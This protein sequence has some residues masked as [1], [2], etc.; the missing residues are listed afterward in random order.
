MAASGINDYVIDTD[1]EGNIGDDE[2]H[3]GDKDGYHDN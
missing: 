1:D 2:I 3:D